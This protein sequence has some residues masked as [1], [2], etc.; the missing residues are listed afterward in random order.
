MEYFRPDVEGFYEVE[1]IYY[2]N[3]LIKDYLWPISQNE[4]IKKSESN[5][6]P[7]M[8]KQYKNNNNM[9]FILTICTVISTIILIN[10]SEEPLHSANGSD[11]VAPGKVVVNSIENIAGGAIIRFTPPTDED[12]LYM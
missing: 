10:C 2:R 9:R 12:L 7:R 1:N 5:P 11:G 3:F 6:K 8:V 4:V